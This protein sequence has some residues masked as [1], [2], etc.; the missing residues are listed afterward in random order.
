MSSTLVERE[1]VVSDR[2][3]DIDITVQREPRG[4]RREREEEF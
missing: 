4:L 2:L 1:T 3:R